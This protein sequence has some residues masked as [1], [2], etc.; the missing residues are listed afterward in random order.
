MTKP[1]LAKT[2]SD[3]GPRRYGWP[4]L[5]PHELD[6]VSVTSILDNF[7]KPWLVGWA[8]KMTAQRAVDDTDIWQAMVAKD[9]ES[10]ALK[11]LKD[12]RWA[13]AGG[14]ADR[15]SVVHAALEAYMAGT[16]VDPA[17]VEAELADKRVPLKLRAATHKMIDGLMDF[18]DDEEP[19]V[20]WSESTVFSREH[21]YAGT[22]DLVCQ[23]RV[24]GTLQPVILDVKTSPRIYDETAL[25]L[26]AYSRADFVGLA[27]GSEHPL[28]PH[29]MTPEPIKY[30]VV[31]RPKPNPAKGEKAYEK[32]VFDLVEENDALFK[33]FLACLALVDG[34]SAVRKSRRP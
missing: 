13:S 27:D 10:G 24:D 33:V 31:V 34:E 7:P 29:L 17:V 28:I 2:G 26:C 8:V 25:Q 19:E 11:Y 6:V 20:Y 23:M 32:A 18:L 14:K 16:Y 3:N 1:A 22:P 5:P 12:A 9:N 30:G 21:G 4:P 15:G